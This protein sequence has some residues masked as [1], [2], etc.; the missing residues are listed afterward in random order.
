[1]RKNKKEL[2]V[3]TR[4]TAFFEF[5]L[6]DNAN[7]TN[8]SRICRL[9]FEIIS[10]EQCPKA[11]ENFRQLTG[12]SVL[13]GEK[14]SARQASYKGTR[15]LRCTPEMIQL[16][17]TVPI[18]SILSSATNANNNTSLLSNSVAGGGSSSSPL[19]ASGVGAATAPAGKDNARNQQAQAERDAINAAFLEG[20]SQDTIYGTL[21]E[22][23]AFGLVPHRFGTLTL[24]NSGPNSNGSQFA[25]I[26]GGEGLPPNLQNGSS[27]AASSDCIVN[28]KNEIDPVATNFSFLDNRHVSLGYLRADANSAAPA[29]ARTSNGEALRKLHSVASALAVD[30]TGR[31][32]A[33]STGSYI[34]VSDCGLIGQ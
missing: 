32:T 25:I 11:T 3:V 6:I 5:A 16:G 24:C 18:A 8:N 17:D 14:K 10:G 4:F 21:I 23:E 29:T 30:K 28:A 9:E 20:K 31:L 27:G 33:S 15:L 1:M 2:P 19:A 12:G 26:V 34:I 22:D 7:P 13:V